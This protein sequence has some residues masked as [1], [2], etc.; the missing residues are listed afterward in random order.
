V[1]SKEAGN[2]APAGNAPVVLKSPVQRQ[3]LRSPLPNPAPNI[4]ESTALA[5]GA[6]RELLELLPRSRPAPL[7]GR[8]LYI[9]ERSFQQLALGSHG[10]AWDV[11]T[12]L[13]RISVL[14]TIHHQVRHDG[15]CLGLIAEGSAESVLEHLRTAWSTRI[16]SWFRRLSV[17]TRRPRLLP[18][19]G[20]LLRLGESVVASCY[21]AG[22]YTFAT[23]CR[24]ADLMY[25]DQRGIAE[26]RRRL[27]ARLDPGELVLISGQLS[28]VE[29]EL[30]DE[31]ADPRRALDRHPPAALSSAQAAIVRM[32]VLSA[33]R[34]EISD[35][36]VDI[37]LPPRES[38]YLRERV[39]CALEVVF[40]RGI[41]KTL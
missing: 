30:A 12:C 10:T 24:A 36:S 40:S 1:R 2:G 35:L 5:V 4:E 23:G 31:G 39:D 34:A 41:L 37:G 38:G 7:A 28:P 19:P 32:E 26:L 6:R 20:S 14:K 18:A 3:R 13:A 29:E 17:R 21:F 11:Y 25:R 16:S 9:H 33:I 8:R 22:Y 27:A 15:V